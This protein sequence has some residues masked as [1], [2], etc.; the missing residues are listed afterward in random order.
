M[1]Q[2][3]LFALP[4]ALLQPSA[5]IVMVA[6]F[7]QLSIG[8]F[9]HSNIDLKLGF[10]EYI[11]SIGDNHRYHHYPNK[12]VG[13]CNYGGEFIVWDILFGTFHK[14]KGERPSDVIGIGTA[15]NYPMTMAGQLIAPFIPDQSVFDD[16]T[17][18]EKKPV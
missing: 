15:P 7:M 4:F 8:I 6:V 3:L 1:V 2:S 14:V 11:F 13:D 12:V 18:S 16:G 9:Q 17:E 10:W 5:E